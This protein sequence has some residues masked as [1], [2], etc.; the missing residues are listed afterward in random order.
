MVR[1]ACSPAGVEEPG[2]EAIG[3]FQ[4]LG[5]SCRC[6]GKHAAFGRSPNRKHSRSTA[7]ALLGGGSEAQDAPRGIAKRR[8]RSAAR[9]TAGSRSALIV[10][11]KRGHGT[12][13]D[14]VEGSEASDRGTVGGKYGE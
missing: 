14:R 10:P 4:E 6:H 9:R 5:R 12:R 8:K 13:P 11:L 1:G 7:V 3:V 2:I